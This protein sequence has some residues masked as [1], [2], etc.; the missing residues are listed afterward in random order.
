M[1]APP[2]HW[3]LKIAPLKDLFL[4]FK[5]GFR[6]REGVDKKKLF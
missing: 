6:K 2:P 4:G 5:N 1:V 3:N